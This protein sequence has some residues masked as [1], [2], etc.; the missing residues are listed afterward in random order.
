MLL[1]YVDLMSHLISPLQ[2]Y[3]AAKQNVK[4]F[5]KTFFQLFLLLG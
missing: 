5:H 3:H 2:V 4:H 1:V